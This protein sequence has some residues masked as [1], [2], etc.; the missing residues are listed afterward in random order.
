M[1]IAHPGD[2]ELAVA[3]GLGEPGRCTFVDRR[4]QR[5]E[6]VWRPL[7]HL[8]DMDLMLSKYR[9]K[10]ADSEDFLD[11]VGNLP[12]PWRAVLR[13]AGKGRM[14][15]AGAFF[16]QERL[17]AEVTMIWPDRREA[18]LEREILSATHPAAPA[19]AT[20]RW[21][22][23]GIRADVPAEFDLHRNDARPGRVAWTFRRSEKARDVLLIE[24]LAM[25]DQ[26]LR[27]PL[28]DWLARELPDGFRAFRQEPKN[29]GPHRGE[30]LISHRKIG[31]LAA[32]RGRRSV[33]M[34]LAWL[35]PQENRL[36]HVSY[37]EPTRQEETQ[38]PAGL[39]VHCCRGAV[40]VGSPQK[41]G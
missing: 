30:V 20:H 12:E 26:W 41:V 35:C 28:R 14:V 22:A 1:E 39:A 21:Q 9:K 25:P 11:V 10:A 3:C 15:N 5:L 19:G 32:L 36:Y 23:L 31:T 2:W 24:R 33:R 37:T 7:K 38:A 40:A 13:R 4:Y 29:C 34:D 18:G 6:V 8:P 17:L 16:R 27:G